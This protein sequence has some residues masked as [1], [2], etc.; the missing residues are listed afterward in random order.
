MTDSQL[1]SFLCPDDPETG[2]LI[3]SKLTPNKRIVWDWAIRKHAEL[4]AH[5]AGCGP[6]PRGLFAEPVRAPR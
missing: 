6:K 5:E 3:V 4:E 1:A 2:K